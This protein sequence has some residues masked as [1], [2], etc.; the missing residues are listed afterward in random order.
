MGNAKRSWKTTFA[1]ILMLATTGF[2]IATNPASAMSPEVIAQLL[3][4]I[5]LILAKDG[6][7][8]G[9]VAVPRN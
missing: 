7:V 6:N 5:G 8:S 4:G 9:T 1:G 3:G 2:G